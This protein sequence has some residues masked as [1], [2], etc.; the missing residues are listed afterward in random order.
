M[1]HNLK[2]PL[3]FDYSPFAQIRGLMKSPSS[4]A[5]QTGPRRRPIQSRAQETVSVIFEATMEVL[6]GEGEASLTTNRIAER[7]GVSIGTLYQYFSTREAIIAAMMEQHR[8]RTMADLEGQLSKLKLANACPRDVLKGFIHTYVQTFAPVDAGMRAVMQLAWKLD[9]HVD[10]AHSLREAAERVSMWLQ[11]FHHPEVQPPSPA[12]AFVL[13][14]ALSGAVRAAMLERSS[15]LESPMF[16]S[17][18]ERVCWA[19][20]SMEKPDRLV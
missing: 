8:S 13:T 2:R 10:L 3:Y 14:R 19:I 16:E 5:G 18:L 1:L 11:Q 6:V 20:L 17:E 7:A 12:L 4:S 15:L 9:Q